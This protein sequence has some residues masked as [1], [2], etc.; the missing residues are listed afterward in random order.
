MGQ[1]FQVDHQRA[2]SGASGRRT[3][4]IQS[5]GDVFHWLLRLDTHHV[6]QLI[7]EF[8]DTVAAC[9]VNLSNM[10]TD[11]SLIKEANDP[12]PL[13]S[14]RIVRERTSQS[15]AFVDLESDLRKAV[16]AR[17]ANA[18]QLALIQGSELAK[19]PDGRAH[20][21]RIS[22]KAAIDA[23]PDLADLIMTSPNSV[24]DFHFVDDINGRTCLHEAAAAGE[25]RMVSLCLD[26][27][28]EVNRKDVYG[29]TA[30]HYSS[31]GGYVDICK[32]LL[33]AS[34]DPSSLDMDN[35]NPLYYAVVN[36]RLECLRVLLEVGKVGLEPTLSDANPLAL[37]CQSGHLD[38]TILLLQH[39][40]KNL[41]NTNGEYP[42]HLAAKEGHV[43]V[44]KLLCVETRETLDMPDK[45]SEWTPLFH[46]ANNG[47]E[48]CVKV[49][50]Q[51]GSNPMATDELGRLAIYYA[52]WF[53][54]MPCTFLLY[55]AISASPRRQTSL[56]QAKG[57]TSSVSRMSPF[58]LGPDA[59][60][61]DAIP[62]LSLPPP[63]MPFRIYGHNYLEKSYLVQLALGQPF[64]AYTTKPSQPPI[65]ITPWTTDPDLRRPHPHA[66]PSL[67]LVMSSRSGK[68]SVPFTLT[69]PLS[70]H[71]DTLSF[72]IQN[73]VELS[74]EFSFYPNFGSKTIGRAAIL[75]SIF[76]GIQDTK[77]I[78]LPVLDHRLHIIGRLTIEV[79]IISPFQ[80][81]ALQVGGTV[82][83]YWKSSAQYSRLGGLGSTMNV[84]KLIAPTHT[85]ASHRSAAA[86]SPRSVTI[87]SLSGDYLHVIVQVTRDLVPVVYSKW[88]LPVNGVDV[89]VCSVS[90]A[91][92]SGIAVGRRMAPN[93]MHAPGTVQEWAAI[94]QTCML[95]LEHLLKVCYRTS[96]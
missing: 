47:H 69:I 93:P 4:R 77:V 37:A 46:A 56:S 45:Y 17:D 27:N 71:Q 95:T 9:L 11:V 73:L 68:S 25:L 2:L 10:G 41:P 6:L 50:L 40:A 70:D 84:S 26:H 28:V 14:E 58:D 65:E 87:S 54:H 24:C 44:C 35:F 96:W 81:V 23:P 92:F 76:Q 21:T 30:L 48:G 83:T 85:S 75:P 74:L 52:A 43:E 13:L 8:A 33:A 94:V 12:D 72:Q 67:K 39:G 38:V 78:H 18:I 62:S 61:H 5:T 66:P 19:L 91:Q 64:S 80:D 29:R 16:A 49:L 86:D 22:W 7:T 51:A 82:E 89:G 57:S 59:M 63:I 79:C 20:V 90:A 34:A 53:G 1:T 32:R 3:A 88:H 60:E 15:R 42:L 31:M 36:G 55:D